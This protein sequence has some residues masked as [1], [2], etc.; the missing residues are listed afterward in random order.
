V[1]SASVHR[2][3]VCIRDVEDPFR[4]NQIRVLERGAVRLCDPLVALEDLLPPEG[5]AGLRR[6]DV[7]QGVAGLDNVSAFVCHRPGGDGQGRQHD[8]LA[9]E[10]HPGV[11]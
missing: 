4:K 7:P 3:D 11:A 6:R 1:L 9:G 8:A 10:D 2:G 5:V